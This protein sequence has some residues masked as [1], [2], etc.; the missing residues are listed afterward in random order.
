MCIPGLGRGIEVRFPA[1]TGDISFLQRAQTGLGVDADPL[2]GGEA[3]C[4]WLLLYLGLHGV[5]RLFLH[6]SL[7]AVVLNTSK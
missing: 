6:T 7:M 4:L 3:R 1:G 2:R 5:M